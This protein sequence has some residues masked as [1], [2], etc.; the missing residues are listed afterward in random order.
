M[1][2]GEADSSL[3]R[4]DRDVELC[5]DLGLIAW[6]G[7]LVVANAIYRE[8]IARSLSQN[9]Q[10]NIPAPEFRWQTA[11]G[12]LDMDALLREFQKFWRRHADTWETKGDY[13][14]AFP[15]LLLMAFLQ[16]V[17]NGGGRIEREYAAGRGRIDL[18]IFF[19]GKTHIIEIKLIHPADGRD[20]TL[21]EGLTQ[22]A[23]YA[24]TTGAD[25]R[26]LVLFD[27][28]PEWRA[29]PWSERLGWETRPSPAGHEV[30]VVWG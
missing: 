16:R 5:L 23:R 1:I 17:I 24:E 7:S 20:G 10:D 11:D 22:I 12:G 25:S 29:K 18:A 3:G 4:N 14:E 21:E 6:D 30:T 9:M 13:T 19:G 8:V 28:R 15:H 2:I 27:R 26:H